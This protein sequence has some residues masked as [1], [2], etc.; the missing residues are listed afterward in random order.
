MK[1]ALIAHDKKKEEIIQLA[2]KFKDTLAQHELYATGT[3]GTMIMG[4]TKLEIHRLKSGP[5][6][7][8]FDIHSADDKF[9]QKTWEKAEAEMQRLALNTAMAKGGL[10]ERDLDAVF[11]GDLLNQCVGAA[12]GLKDFSLPYFGLSRHPGSGGHA[13]H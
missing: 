5:L 2:K 13:H 9:G 8:C 4:E 1:I 11:A 10:S 6:G 12:Y 3:T 7:G